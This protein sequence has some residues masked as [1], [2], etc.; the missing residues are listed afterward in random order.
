M[1]ERSP[2]DIQDILHPQYRP[3]VDFNDAKSTDEN[4]KSTDTGTAIRQTLETADIKCGSLHFLGNRSDYDE[5]DGPF[6]PLYYCSV[7]IIAME[8][9]EHQQSAYSQVHDAAKLGRLHDLPQLYVLTMPGVHPN[10]FVDANIE[11]YTS[12]SRFFHSNVVAALAEIVIVNNNLTAKDAS[13]ISIAGLLHDSATVAG[14]DTTKMVDKKLFDEEKLVKRIL[15]GEEMATVLQENGTS[16]ERIQAI[17][18]GDGQLGQILDFCDQFGYAVTDAYKAFGSYDELPAGKGVQIKELLEHDPH[19]MDLIFSMKIDSASGQLYCEDQDRLTRYLRL[20]AL[21]HHELY[22]DPNAQMVEIAV[23]V[24]ILKKIWAEQSG[25]VTSEKTID[26]DFLLNNGLDQLKSV[27]AQRLDV[28]GGTT[29]L[30]VHLA[31]Q[32]NEMDISFYEYQTPKQAEEYRDK[33]AK[34]GRVILGEADYTKGFNPRTNILVKTKNG[35]LVPY[36][37]ANPEETA[38]INDIVNAVKTI[39]IYH[40]KKEIEM[41]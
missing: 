35:E 20:R 6:I 5:Y 40:G 26:I 25:K 14:G 34:Q 16:P 11:M 30:N 39:R 36:A 28:S 2:S 15:E 13:E 19:L 12:H 8:R 24:P 41:N 17:I 29:M 23:I 33:I 10:E 3:V 27:I 22:L 32:I 18:D 31:Q 7:P 9:D 38:K 37:E 4:G 1:V 21:L